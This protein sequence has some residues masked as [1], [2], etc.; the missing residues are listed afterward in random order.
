[1]S[2]S[3]VTLVYCHKTTEARIEFSLKVAKCLNFSTVGLTAK[4]EGD[5]LD[6]GLKLGRDG[7]RFC[8]TIS[9]QR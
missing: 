3:S 5:P 2:S 4:F 6:W 8:C 9:Q 1:M 7:L